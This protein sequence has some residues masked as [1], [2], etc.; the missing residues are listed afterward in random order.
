MTLPTGKYLIR[1]KCFDSFVQRAAHEDHSLLPKP[2][3]SIASGQRAYPRTTRGRATQ[4]DT[5][6]LGEVTN[7]M[8]HV[9]TPLFSQPPRPSTTGHQDPPPRLRNGDD[10]QRTST[11]PTTRIDERP[12]GPAST[13]I[14]GRRRAPTNIHARPAPPSRNADDGPPRSLTIGYQDPPPQLTSF[15]VRPTPTID[16]WPRGPTIDGRRR[17]PTNVHG[18]TGAHH[19]PRQT[20]TGAHDHDWQTQ[21]HHRQFPSL[22][23]SST[24][25]LFLAYPISPEKPRDADIT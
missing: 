1:N 18:A 20:D 12:R 21:S 10:H 13:T 4:L 11:G 16:G 25:T 8:S 9:T 15:Y 2:I 17:A 3:V 24:P 6:Q 14:D 5:S 23:P 7:A 22:P 19:H